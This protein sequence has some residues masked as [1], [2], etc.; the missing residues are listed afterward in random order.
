MLLPRMPAILTRPIAGKSD[1]VSSYYREACRYD[2]RLFV[3][4]F[5]NAHIYGE[6]SEMHDHFIDEDSKSQQIRGV[7]R[8]IAAPRGNAKTTF[9]TLIKPIH[10]IV[11][12]YESFILVIGYSGTDA[13]DKVRDIR[14]ELMENELLKQ[15]YGDLIPKNAA[16]S[17]FKTTTGIRVA[18]R[19]RGK[20][21]RGIKSGKDR[22]SLIILDDIESLQSTNTPEQ[23]LKTKNWFQKDVIG[24]CR[25]DKT[26]NIDLVGTIIHEDSLLADLRKTPGWEGRKYRAIE[27]FSDRQDLWDEWRKIYCDLKNIKAVKDARAFYEKNE[28]QMLDGV[29]VLWPDGDSYY[30]LMEFMVVN[31]TAAFYSEKQNEPFDPSRQI[32]R[33]QNCSRFKVVW[34]WD[35]QWMKFFKFDSDLWTHKDHGFIIS[36]ADGFL[37]SSDLKKIIMAFDPAIADKEKVDYAAISVVAQDQNDQIYLL[38][39]WMEQKPPSVQVEAICRMQEKWATEKLYLE[40]NNFQRLYK[41]VINDH[42][43]NFHPNLS[44]NIDPIIQ[45]K[46]KIG[47]IGTLQ[48]YFDNNWIFL[49]DQLPGDYI[50]QIRLFPTDHDDGPDSLETAVRKLRRPRNLQTIIKTNQIV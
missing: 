21:I 5:F 19:S 47:R 41:T 39:A 7:K 35:K 38:D 49:S 14:D 44:I 4:H 45:H 17:D 29:R 42:I 15:V 2:Y 24:C 46:N 31:G 28:K 22:P 10:G 16:A 1:P 27:S 6:F 43:S 37:H 40:A 18:G 30:S 26:T 32:L 12:G 50:D 9:K 33:P 36:M 20:A 25:T 3:R 8:A 13:R 23:R 11:Y 48:P 34:P